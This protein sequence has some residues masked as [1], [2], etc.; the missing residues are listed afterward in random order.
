MHNI[1]TFSE[2]VSRFKTF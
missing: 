1:Y 2:L